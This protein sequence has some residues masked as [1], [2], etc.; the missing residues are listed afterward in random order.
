MKN[1]ITN[2]AGYNLLVVLSMIYMS[3]ML[4][5]AVLTNRYVGSDHLFVLGGTFI[6]PLL[7]ILDDIIAE[8][9][10]YKIA[11]NLIVIG[12]LSQMVFM[13]LCWLVMVTPHPDFF[14]NKETYD[15]ILG[16]SFVR[17]TLS[18]FFAYIIANITNAYLLTKWKVLLKGKK[19]WLRSIGSSIISEGLYSFI[20]IMLMQIQAIPLGDIFKVIAISYSI[21]IIYNIVLAGPANLLVNQLKI[22]SNID[23]Y[24]FPDEFTP[25]QYSSNMEKANAN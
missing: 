21:K 23:I 13:A 5:S 14:T 15:Q 12:F 9:Y 17:I 11:R 8:I 16:S 24:N 10:G 20:A 7:F 2:N 19:F 3:V 6:S 4:C 22:L 1:K 18:G 25:F